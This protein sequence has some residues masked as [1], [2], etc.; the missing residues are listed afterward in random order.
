MTSGEFTNARISVEFLRKHFSYDAETGKITR[1]KSS[2]SDT[3]GE[4]AGTVERHNGRLYRRIY[5]KGTRF[6]AQQL[7]WILHWGKYPT[8]II[9]HIDNDGLNNR[10]KNLQDITQQKNVVKEAIKNAANIYELPSGK[11]YVSID[12]K[13][14]GSYASYKEARE[15]RRNYNDQR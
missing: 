12:K 8:D 7:A 4:E 10:I 15:V 1:I 14:L 2:R 5:F 11:F 3:I 6:Y 13:Y 9:D